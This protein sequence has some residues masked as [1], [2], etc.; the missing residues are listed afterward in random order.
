MTIA[1]RLIPILI[2]ILALLG[3]PAAPARAQDEV[4]GY[5]WSLE[6]RFEHNYDGILTI[7]V[8][9]WEHGDLVSVDQTSTEIVHCKPVGA[10]YL[11][12]GDAV[13]KGGHLNC[14]LDLA[15]VVQRNH[16]LQI[17]DVDVYGSILMRGRMITHQQNVAP[18]FSHP[19]ATYS[20][21][22][23]QTS[24]VTLGQTLWN[25]SDP[26]QATF[27]NVVGAAW[28]T[29][30]LS[31]E[32]SLYGTCGAQFYAGGQ[33]QLVPSNGERAR[34]HT[35][36]N[37]FLIGSDGVSHFNG[38]MSSLLIDPGNSVH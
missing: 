16:G 22:F 1:T 10:V 26:I 29:Y 19:D 33:K 6:F 17:D 8:G 5:L 34:F 30:T 38:R 37:E 31:Y 9:P 15:S 20:I 23:T 32:C 7:E 25:E 21:D 3:M 14:L 35:G 24:A 27:P 13:F 4:Y 2:V 28:Q 18:I 11:E 36:P 12:N